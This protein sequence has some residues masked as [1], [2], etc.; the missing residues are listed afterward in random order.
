[1]QQLIQLIEKEKLGNQPA[2][3]YTLIIDDK[4]VV[5]G[6]LFVIKTTKKT[7]KLMI[8]APFHEAVLKEQLTINTLIKHP[9][10]MLLA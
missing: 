8:P 2:K 3:Q 4:Q 6:A 5:H 9:Q 10:V 7:F 1:M